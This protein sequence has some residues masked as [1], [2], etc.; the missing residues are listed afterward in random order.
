MRYYLHIAEDG[1]FIED[2]EGQEFSDEHA[3]RREAIIA[4]ASIAK[5]AFVGGS[6]RRVEIDVRKEN[7]TILKVVIS[8]AIEE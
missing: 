1:R 8:L 7:M 4:G 2:E 3:V 5:D 6:A